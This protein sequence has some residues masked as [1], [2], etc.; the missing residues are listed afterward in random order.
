VWQVIRRRSQHIHEPNEVRILR[1]VRDSSALS[2]IEIAKATGLHKATITD[3]VTKLIEAGFLEDTGEVETRKNVG[4]KRVLLRFI[5][6]A[7]L[8]AGVDIRMT[9]ATMAITD[10]NA[11]VLSQESFDYDPVDSVEE[12]FSRAAHTI[13]ALLKSA[14]HSASKLV[15]IGIGV[16]GIIDYSTNTLVLS[17]NKKSWQGKSLSTLLE[18][19]FSVPVYVENDVKTMALGEYLLGAAQRTKDFVHVWVGEGV[20]AGIM[21]N[22]QLLHGI[23]SSAGEIGYNS[24]E[25]S[26]VYKENF[27]LTYRD[28]E[29]FGEI[30]TDANLV[31]SYRRNSPDTNGEDLSVQ[32]I[33]HRARLGDPIAQGVIEEFVSL[34]SILCINMV[35]T[36]N[37]EIIVIGGKLAESYPGIAGM[38]QVKIHRDLLTPP[39]EAVRVRA[40]THR[41]NGVILGAAGLVLYELFEPVQQVSVRTARRQSAS[42]PLQPFT[43]QG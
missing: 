36:L 37:P 17:Y 6:T 24:L 4:R 23:T 29:L 30:L 21:I 20:G 3:L 5:P 27:P 2:R 10:L 43:M 41:E 12:V 25:S 26:A 14:R 28:Q 11:R 19:E 7:G 39:A 16:Q 1:L 35:N 31:E 42:S 40:A 32:V 22:G 33:A 18:K 38:L 15:G 8:V 34:L 9:H 13:T